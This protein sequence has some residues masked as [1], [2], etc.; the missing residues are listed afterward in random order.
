MPDVMPT[1]Y[2]DIKTYD[3]INNDSIKEELTVFNQTNSIVNETDT[4]YF[5]NKAKLSVVGS[6]S[7]F[8]SRNV[9]NSMSE[10]QQQMHME[11]TACFRRESTKHTCMSQCDDKNDEIQI[12]TESLDTD[13]TSILIGEGLSCSQSRSG[14][15][16]AIPQYSGMD[17]FFNQ[18]QHN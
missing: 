10:G 4:P 11:Q 17:T 7:G 1:F 2:N 14:S 9:V 5:S 12:V 16:A 13:T 18:S 3:R 8:G 15:R 6:V